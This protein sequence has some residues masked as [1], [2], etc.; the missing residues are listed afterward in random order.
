MNFGT[1]NNRKQSKIERIKNANRLFL[2]KARAS[3][4]VQVVKNLPA[5]TGD[6]DLILG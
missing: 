6:M 4:M 2:I 3:Y 1:G 5:N